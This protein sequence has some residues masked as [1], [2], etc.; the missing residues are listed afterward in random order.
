MP[1]SLTHFFQQH[2]TSPPSSYLLSYHLPVWIRFDLQGALSPD[3]AGYF[4]QV[5]HRAIALFEAAFAPTD[6][7]LLVYQE[8]RYKR[9]RIR[10]RNYLFRQLGIGK[11]DLT[12]RK[13]WV[14]NNAATYHEGHWIQAFFSTTAARIP[15]RALLAAISR[16]D[17]PAP[18]RPT[19]RGPLYFFN[20]T[21]GLIFYMYD[22]RGLVISSTSP[23]TVWPF[24]QNYNDW[25]LDYDRRKIDELFINS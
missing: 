14:P 7:V 20:Q 2:A 3:D 24:Y 13:S 21:R 5:E 25:I 15:H 17:F 22:D 6:E 1:S 23:E 19:I 16:L 10:T 4:L 8:P 9:S 18:G 11:S 12:F